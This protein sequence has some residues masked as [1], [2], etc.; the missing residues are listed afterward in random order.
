LQQLL[1]GVQ[2]PAIAGQANCNQQVLAFALHIAF[3]VI[4]QKSPCFKCAFYDTKSVILLNRQRQEKIFFQA[5]G[6]NT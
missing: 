2:V 1:T 4:K 3:H 5:G 6:K